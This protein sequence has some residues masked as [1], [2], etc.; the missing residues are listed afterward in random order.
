MQTFVKRC[1]RLRP[2]C[3]LNPESFKSYSTTRWVQVVQ[4]SCGFAPTLKV[5]LVTIGERVPSEVGLCWAAQRTGWDAD[6]TQQGR[7]WFFSLTSAS[8]PLSFFMSAQSCIAVK[9]MS[10]RTLAFFPSYWLA[11]PIEP[12]HTHLG[13]TL[14]AGVPH[15]WGT[16]KVWAADGRNQDETG[17]TSYWGTPHL[18]TSTCTAYH[19]IFSCGL[20]GFHC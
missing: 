2:C 3:R 5:V 6:R 15:C 13:I 19:G 16:G 17:G 20:Q 7:E 10:F 18:V 9:L 8:S 14:R 11:A 1:P 4:Q 12:S